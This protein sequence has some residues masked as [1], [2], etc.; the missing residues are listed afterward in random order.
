MKR[1]LLF[2][3]LFLATTVS[4][5]YGQNQTKNLSE[6]VPFVVSSNSGLSAQRAKLDAKENQMKEAAT[7]SRAVMNQ[8]NE[9]FRVLKEEYLKMLSSEMQKTTDSQLLTQ[10]KEE[11]AR[12]SQTTGT[13]T[14]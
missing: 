14:R 10:L 11:A 6:P 7:A 1:H 3:G 9:E 4:I 2:V 12:Y 8:L 5:T 13:L